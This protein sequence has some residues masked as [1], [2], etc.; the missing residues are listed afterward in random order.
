MRTRCIRG[1]EASRRKEGEKPDQNTLGFL[2]WRE[3]KWEEF[4]SIH[5]KRF[6][7]AADDSDIQCVRNVRY[8]H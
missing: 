3:K 5:P 6:P 1:G 7:R 2:I 8:V 4:F